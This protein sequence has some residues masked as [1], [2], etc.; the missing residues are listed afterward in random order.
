MNSALKRRR[1]QDSEDTHKNVTTALKAILQ[2]K[3][4]TVAAPFGLYAQLLK[5]S[6][7]KMIPLGKL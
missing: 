1:F 6:T 2:Q 5:G 7:S 4:R 3:F